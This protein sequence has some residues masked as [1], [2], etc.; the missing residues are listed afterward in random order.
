MIDSPITILIV[1]DNKPTLL[2]EAAVDSVLRQ[3]FGN[4]QGILLDSGLLHEQGF[5][6]RVPWAGDPRLVIKS[7]ETPALRRKKAMAP[8][9]QRVFSPLA[10]CTES[11]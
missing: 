6:G 5:F 8:A 10:W 1:S 9:F 4:W 3:T 2:A 7:P 11:W